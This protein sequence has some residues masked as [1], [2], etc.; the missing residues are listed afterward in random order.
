[1]FL[2]EL[3]LLTNPPSLLV[4]NKQ[5][6]MLIK[7][8]SLLV[9]SWCSAG[10]VYVIQERTPNSYSTVTWPH[11]HEDAR[12][13]Q[14]ARHCSP[15]SACLPALL[16]SSCPPRGPPHAASPPTLCLRL[17][18]R[19]RC[20]GGAPANRSLLISPFAAL[21]KQSSQPPKAVSSKTLLLLVG[22][23]WL[24]CRAAPPPRSTTK[25]AGRR[26]ADRPC[27]AQQ[28]H[29]LPCCST[30]HGGRRA[31]R[32]EGFEGNHHQPPPGVVAGGCSCWCVAGGGCLPPPGAR[33]CRPPGA[34]RAV[35]RGRWRCWALAVTA[36]W[37]W[38]LL[39]ARSL[40]RCPGAAWAVLPPGGGRWLRGACVVRLWR[41]ASRC[42]NERECYR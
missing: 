30:H 27:S 23:G 7:I 2:E 31:R 33:D 3:L 18:M 6:R 11:Q 24:R 5:G 20:A 1:M 12:P 36:R 22:G 17:R 16:P 38:L 32:R 25:N 19:P 9:C 14:R 40:G 8:S 29:L 21:Q 26:R 37:C 13:A 39:R 34:R 35:R 28:Q 10:V 41:A 42:K 4:A 15:R